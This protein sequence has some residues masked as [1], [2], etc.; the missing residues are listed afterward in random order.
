ML[1]RDETFGTLDSI[2]FSRSLFVE[3]YELTYISYV[4]RIMASYVRL[5]SV[6][7]D[8]PYVLW[9]LCQFSSLLAIICLCISCNFLCF[10]SRNGI[11]PM[12]REVTFH[13]DSHRDIFK[14]VIIFIDLALLRLSTIVLS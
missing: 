11:E 7:I 6:E 3:H 13:R 9:H 8:R 4:Q 12:S 1:D 2:N 14:L 10:L 5:C